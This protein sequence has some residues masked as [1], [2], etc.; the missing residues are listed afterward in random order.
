MKTPKN[1]DILKKL[2]ELKPNELL[3]EKF[4]FSAVNYTEGEFDTVKDVP[5]C[6]TA[7]CLAGQLPQLH[8]GWYFGSEG[9]LR[10][11][12]FVHEGSPPEIEDEVFLNVT[13]NLESF[14]GLKFRLIDTI[15]FPYPKS[16]VPIKI[17]KL[18]D[19]ATL[20]QV[21]YNL[22]LIIAAIERGELDAYIAD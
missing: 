17:L 14:F 20:S 16:P 9:W 12:D 6:G 7:G 2:A 8:K 19:R 1:F 22:R 5:N 4:D 21:Q 15:F 11:R 3:H 18:S 13:K 10:Y